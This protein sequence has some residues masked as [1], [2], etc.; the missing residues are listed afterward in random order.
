MAIKSQAGGPCQSDVLDKTNARINVTPTSGMPVPGF[1]GTKSR[2][3]AH[4]NQGKVV[5]YTKSANYGRKGG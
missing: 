1:P 2:D 3:A 5:F 4:P